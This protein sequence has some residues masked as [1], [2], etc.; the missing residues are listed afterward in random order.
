M[1]DAKFKE[2]IEEMNKLREANGL[3]RNGRKYS[4]V[5]DRV[6]LFRKMWGSEFGI[7]TQVDYGAGFE[8]GAVIVATA[9][10]MQGSNILASGH[11]MQFVGSSEINM[12]S[13]VEACETNAVGRAL[14][15]FGLAGGEFPSAGEM[16]SVDR[17]SDI[18]KSD[19]VKPSTQSATMVSNQQFNR[20]IPDVSKDQVWTQP[21]EHLDL[22]VADINKINS[23]DELPVYWEKLSK[24]REVLGKSTK[25]GIA[26]LKSAFATRIAQLER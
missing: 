7:E 26:E 16:L 10:I 25:D 9:K 1:M 23:K 19:I 2:V 22:I 20:Y 13:A 8:R 21:F 11:A 5:R 15:F 17:K 4:L 24:F 14:A 6:E 3:E 18:V 12:T